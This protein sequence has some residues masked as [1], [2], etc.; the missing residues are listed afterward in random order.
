[1]ASAQTQGKKDKQAIAREI[2]K[3]KKKHLMKTFL[4]Q[5]LR[6]PFCAPLGQIVHLSQKTCAALKI[7]KE[8]A[9]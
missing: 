1:M 6:K 7:S 2:D 8:H 9:Q 4:K 5:G 3:K